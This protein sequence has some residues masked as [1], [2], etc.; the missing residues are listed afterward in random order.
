MKR[1][2]NNL[3]LG[4]FIALSL[5]EMIIAQMPDTIYVL[6]HN[7]RFLLENHDNDH[8]TNYGIFDN[9]DSTITVPN[10]ILVDTLKIIWDMQSATE[11]EYLTGIE[12]FTSLKHFELFQLGG[13]KSLKFLNHSAIESIMINV[14]WADSL[15]ISDCPSFKSILSGGGMYGP[16]FEYISISNCQSF[17]SWKAYNARVSNLEIINCDNLLSFPFFSMDGGFADAKIIDCDK[18]N[19]IRAGDLS[20]SAFGTL[21]VDDCDSLEKIEY[22]YGKEI[23]ISNCF[24][25]TRLDVESGG[26]LSKCNLNNLPNLTKLDLGG[27][28][29][30]G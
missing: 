8:G 12:Q 21:I 13:V 17:N 1:S 16:S 20:G 15:V 3:L 26:A 24:N 11:I 9:G 14:G 25:F 27:I 22:L 19:Y 30:D 23:E 6:D 2:I 10:I 4:L 29:G 18:I 5:Q 7:L 28:H